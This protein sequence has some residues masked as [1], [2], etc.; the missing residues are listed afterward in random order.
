MDRGDEKK[1]ITR[2]AGLMSVATLIS[3]ILGYI[4]DMILAGFFGAT[5]VADTFFVAFR[6][7][8]PAENSL[9][10]DQCLPLLF[11]CL[12]SIRRNRGNRKREDSSE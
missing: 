11:P 3:R 12:Q 9:R 8:E 4:K 1:N 2:A 10:K 6:I 7:P 5:G